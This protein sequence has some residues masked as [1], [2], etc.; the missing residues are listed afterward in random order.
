MLYWRRL[1][2]RSHWFIHHCWSFVITKLNFFI[3]NWLFIN[4]KLT[5]CLICRYL[6][7][8]WK[9]SRWFS[10]LLKILAIKLVGN[11]ALIRLLFRV[12][13]K[14]SLANITELWSFDVLLCFH[15]LKFYIFNCHS[16]YPY[17]C[18]SILSS[19]LKG[20][21]SILCKSL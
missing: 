3:S 11:T 9:L 8:L 1:S 6:E 16:V 12:N 5:T 19:D 4:T 2:L 7:T 20:L 14:T 18:K 13:T 21:F 17:S 10:A 15:K